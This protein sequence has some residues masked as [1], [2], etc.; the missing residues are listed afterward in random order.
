LSTGPRAWEISIQEISADAVA[1]EYLSFDFTPSYSGRPDYLSLLPSL[2]VTVGFLMLPWILVLRG[3]FNEV[4]LLSVPNGRRFRCDARQQDIDSKHNEP[5]E[6]LLLPNLI[7]GYDLELS[8][9]D[10]T[11]LVAEEYGLSRPSITDN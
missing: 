7:P 3:Q 9:I 8:S 11:N 4:Y 6:E 5:L 2:L 10:V 1:R